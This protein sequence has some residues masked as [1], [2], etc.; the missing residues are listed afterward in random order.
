MTDPNKPQDSYKQSDPN[1]EL[2][3]R[4]FDTQSADGKKGPDNGL[5]PR[6]MYNKRVTEVAAVLSPEYAAAKGGRESWL[7]GKQK[8]QCESAGIPR[9]PFS[10]GLEVRVVPYYSQ[11]E[12]QEKA[13]QIGADPK[14]F[15]NYMAT[16]T[17]EEECQ[18][19]L[20]G[21]KKAKEKGWIT[22]DRCEEMTAP[23]NGSLP[24]KPECG[25]PKKGR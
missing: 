13:R 25:P 22:E 11:G 7:I 6:E 19:Y 3:W 18:A 23:Y 24:G 1:S 17:P 12:K 15:P 16:L 2:Y 4:K 10:G 20:E 9:E 8:D 21:V 5:D 14:D